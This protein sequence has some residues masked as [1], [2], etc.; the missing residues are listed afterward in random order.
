MFSYLLQRHPWHFIRID[1]GWPTSGSWAPCHLF[2]FSN[3]KIPLQSSKLDFWQIFAIEKKGGGKRQVGLGQEK[4]GRRTRNR[5][6]HQ[7][8][9]LVTSTLILS[10]TIDRKVFSRLLRKFWQ[11]VVVDT[12][13][14]MGISLQPLYTK[15]IK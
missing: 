4:G 8:L 13:F 5:W 2:P 15:W 7:I 3:F 6:L 14:H 12:W 1:Q 10:F 11:T 9:E